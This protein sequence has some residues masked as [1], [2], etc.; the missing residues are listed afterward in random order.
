MSYSAIHNYVSAVE[1]YYK[2]N[3]VFLNV[4]KINKFIPEH[5]KG[6]ADR[7]YTHADI[8]KMLE[9]ADSRYQ[10]GTKNGDYCYCKREL[11]ELVVYA[12][13]FLFF[14]SYFPLVFLS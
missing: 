6:K 11:N 13:K 1:S 5:V 7:A 3:D 4:R 8:G 12:F 2:I 9:V 14:L 10:K